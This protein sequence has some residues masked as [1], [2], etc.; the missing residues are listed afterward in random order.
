MFTCTKVVTRFHGITG[1]DMNYT[2]YLLTLKLNHNQIQL[3]W[4]ISLTF[5]VASGTMI[6]NIPNVGAPV[7]STRIQ[8]YTAPSLI[9][10]LINKMHQ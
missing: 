8:V 7:N 1:Y 3:F 10:K 4:Y 5:F 6:L 2:L 9:L